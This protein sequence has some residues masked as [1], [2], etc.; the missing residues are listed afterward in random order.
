MRGRASARPDLCGVGL[1]RGRRQAL[2]Q[3]LE[4]TAA[5][6]LLEDHVY[7]AHAFE[8]L[9][10]DLLLLLTARVRLDGEGDGLAV[11]DGHLGK[12]QPLPAA[13]MRGAVDGD[14]HDRLARLE[15]DLADPALRLAE[16]ARP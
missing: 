16:I 13:D 2:A 7:R 15:R 14:G 1:G 12:A 9:V 4:H 5:A 11:L 10:R 3:P 6:V 8:D